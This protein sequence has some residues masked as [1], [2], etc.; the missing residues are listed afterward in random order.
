MTR[1]SLSVVFAGSGGAGAMTAG[2]LFL[3]AAA[4]AGYYGVMTQLF[5]AQVRG[6]ESAALVH[7][8]VD[9]VESPPDFFD[10]FVA[11]D[12]KKIDQFAPEIPL[13]ETSAVIADPSAGPVPGSIAKS[14][15]RIFEVAFDDPGATKLEQ[16]L[17]GRRANVCA[18]GLIGGLIGLSIEQLEAALETALGKK[19]KDVL[20]SNRRA[21]RH[22]IGLAK[23]LPLSLQLS[24]PTSDD[25][26]WLITGN[27]AVAF[28]ALR[29]GVRF[30]GCYPITPA[31]DLVEWLAPRI[32]E[33]GGNLVLAE[34][35]LASIN[36]VL[37]ASYGGIPAMTVTAGPG[38]ALMT[39]T[40]GL[41]VAAEIP[42][43]IVDVM[44]A[45]PS[46]GIAS[47]TEQSDLN[48]AIYGGHGDAPRVVVAPIS[49]GDCAVTSEWAVY[50]SERMQTPVLVLSDQ[51]LG[52]A[53]AAIPRPLRRPPPSKRLVESATTGPFKRYAVGADPVTAMPLPGTPNREWVAEG[54]THNEAGLP[55]SGAGAHAAQ[56]N[57]RARKFDLFDPGPFWGEMWGEGDTAIVT[58]G[59]CVAAAREAA[60][61]RTEAGQPTRVIALRVLSPVPRKAILEKLQG[62]KRVVVLEQNHSG[63][64]LKHLLAN[65][66]VPV[67]AEGISRPGPLPFRPNEIVRQLA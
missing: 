13:N 55:V 44:R 4:S 35:E 17:R 60:A 41:G 66:S 6:G 34:D 37:G 5:G 53:K 58:F 50:I 43:V 45:G 10:V 42:A 63:Q 7:I 27:Q 36:M 9:P 54:L 47:K 49:I 28:G 25:D 56:I 3:Q 12:W 65:K 40:I 21:L 61:R 52:Q 19:S 59:S 22:G 32:R 15:P 51:A 14:R 18:A 31:T 24:S 67:S 29:G 64:L 33:L 62:V 8:S 39:E 2:T 20:E 26:R 1:P 46:T 16:A 23:T 38:L 11:I 48:I 30:V 57:K